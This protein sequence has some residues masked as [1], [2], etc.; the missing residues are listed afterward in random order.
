VNEC[1]IYK[2]YKSIV[3]I[4]DLGNK[5]IYTLYLTAEGAHIFILPKMTLKF[6]I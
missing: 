1:S 4:F 6:H 2:S 5:K 3:D